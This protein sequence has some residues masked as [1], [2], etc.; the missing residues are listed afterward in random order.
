MRLRAVALVRKRPHGGTRAV[1]GTPLPKALTDEEQERLLATLAD[2]TSEADRR[3]RVLF[4]L[5]LRTGIRIGSALGIRVEDV[6]LDRGEIHLRRMKFRRE[7]VVY[8]PGT[9]VEL[10]R[11]WLGVRTSGHMFVGQASA[12]ITPRHIARRLA[13]WCERA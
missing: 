7:H 11:D 1:C 8:M 3:D 9:L 13:V 12:P 10:L 2:A 5:M 4:E 6:A